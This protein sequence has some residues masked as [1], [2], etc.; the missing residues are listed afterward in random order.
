MR[1]AFS[2][3]LC[4]SPSAWGAENFLKNRS[5]ASKRS[6][7]FSFSLVSFT[8]VAL[9]ARPPKRMF[10]PQD[11]HGSISPLILL[12]YR[13][14]M[15][16]GG[17]SPDERQ[18]LG[19]KKTDR[20]RKIAARWVFT[21]LEIMLRCSAAGLNFIIIPLA[22]NAPLEFLTGFNFPCQDQIKKEPYSIFTSRSPFL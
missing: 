1:C 12:L 6:N 20:M 19:E 14:V 22:F 7:P 8:Q 2:F 10:G 4:I 3:N 15:D 5:P 9:L 11:G 16:G 18:I 21:P 17:V 13:M